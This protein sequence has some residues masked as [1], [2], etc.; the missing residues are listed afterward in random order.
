M[1]TRVHSPPFHDFTVVAPL[2]P[3]A[4]ASHSGGCGP[5]HDFTVVAPLKLVTMSNASPGPSPS[6]TSPSWLH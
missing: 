4:L 3:G 6:T 1:I 2:K 5:F